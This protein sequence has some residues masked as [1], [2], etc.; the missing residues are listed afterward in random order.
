LRRVEVS[1]LNI[2]DLQ[3]REDHW[4]VLDLIGKRRHIRTVPVPDWVKAALDSWVTA[5]AIVDGRLFRCVS[6]TGTI[7][8][9]GITGKIVWHIVKRYANTAGFQQLAPHDCRRSCARLCHDAG[10]ELEQ[11]QFLLGHASVE[12]TERYLAR[13]RQCL[14]SQFTSIPRGQLGKLT[15]EA[16]CPQRKPA[17]QD[18]VPESPT[19][20]WE[21]HRGLAMSF[22]IRAQEST[23][24]KPL[25]LAAP[26]PSEKMHSASADCASAPVGR[27]DSP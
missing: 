1:K 20:T 24:P 17:V 22:A 21:R 26:L 23:N 5:A 2:G 9:S 4:V 3:Q 14:N 16:F 6:R 7:W 11:I 25:P 12:T 18:A 10:G 8:G 13:G 27:T 19:T 15:A